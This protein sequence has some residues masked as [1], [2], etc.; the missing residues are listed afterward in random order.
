MCYTTF[1]LILSL[2]NKKYFLDQIWQ[3][4]TNSKMSAFQHET[5]AFPFFYTQIKCIKANDM[6]YTHVGV[7]ES[8]CGKLY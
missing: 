7:N 1:S 2:T 6:S 5:F 4:T 8:V 3:F